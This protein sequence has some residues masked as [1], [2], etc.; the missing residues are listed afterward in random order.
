MSELKLALL[1]GAESK[2]WLAGLEKQIDRLE[3]L[4]SLLA[5][6]DK[7][8]EG[9]EDDGLIPK[10]NNR[11][12]RK[13]IDLNEEAE[14]EIN[15]F[16]DDN[17]EEEKPKRKKKLTCEEVKEA[18]KARIER[19]IDENNMK[20]PEARKEVLGILRKQFQVVSI[21]DLQEEQFADAIA[22]ME[23]EN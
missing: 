10:K 9:E 11:S 20:G 5:S 15:N 21:R 8:K 17:E 3:S 2:A 19:L 16:S 12:K 13:N 22:A 23:E 4:Q 1:V 14:E 7:E 18:C 6:G